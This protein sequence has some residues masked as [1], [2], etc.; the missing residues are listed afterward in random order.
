MRMATRLVPIT[1]SII[2]F[3]SLISFQCSKKS[4][5]F[6][7]FRMYTQSD[8]GSLDPFFSTDVVSGRILAMICNGIF[9]I[10]AHGN[11]V[12]EIAESFNFDGKHLH[13][14][15][16][17]GIFFHNGRECTSDD[18]IFCLNRIRYG[19]NP[20]SPRKWIFSSVKHI[21]KNNAYSLSIF[22]NK[23][24]ATFPFLLTLPSCFIVAPESN[25][26]KNTVVG[27]GPFKL[28]EWKQDE[29][30][31]LLRNSRYFKGCPSIEGIEYRIIPDDL[32]ARFEFTSGNL[33]Y[34]EVPLFLKKLQVGK[35]YNCIDIPDPIVHY[36]ALNNRRF[37]FS[38][39]RFRR[40]LNMAID[41]KAIV[42]ALFDSRFELIYGPIPQGI[43][44]Y[45]S[46]SNDILEY[47]PTLAQQIFKEF[48]TS[49]KR[50]TLL[51]KADYQFE[52]IARAIQYFLEKSGFQ[53]TVRTLEW[54]A[55][56]SKVLRG[57]FDMAYFTWYGDYPEPENY[58]FPLFHS[59]NA[60]IGG[61]RSFYARKEVDLLLEKAQQNVD[62]QKRFDIYRQV[63][64]IILE[65]APW[66][67]L[68]TSKKRI[69]L[70]ERVKGFVPPPSYSAFRGEALYFEHQNGR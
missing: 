2:I 51:V 30:I 11:L 69:A 49:K 47:N 50:F 9:T 68:W 10:D 41:K 22:L 6:S 44:G 35:K 66:I 26:A 59:R 16:R 60:G 57:D 43:G 27:T 37:P 4:K 64:G 17:R 42:K 67:F 54:S 23:H 62:A 24:H 45:N 52:V 36:V 31:V 65:D 13:I 29:R 48:N 18:V 40:A 56:K 38:N 28:S 70:S 34:F 32:T 61:N 20:T 14:Q 55:L 25:F 21:K 7:L 19:E 53:I 58:L 63:E 12:G 15:L 3:F 8:P 46:N 1:L 33:D 5:D 39:A